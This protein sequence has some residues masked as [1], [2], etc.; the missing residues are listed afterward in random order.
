MLLGGMT[1]DSRVCR[2]V[3]MLV[4]DIYVDM[5]GTD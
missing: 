4:L 1:L 3:F 5:Q 2:Y